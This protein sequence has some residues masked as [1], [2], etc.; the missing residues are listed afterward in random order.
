MG[1]VSHTTETLVAS[2]YG[3]LIIY[4]YRACMALIVANSVVDPNTLNLD[5][6]PNPRFNS[7]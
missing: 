5:P 1:E 4:Y 3:Y 6:D 7:Y 2:H